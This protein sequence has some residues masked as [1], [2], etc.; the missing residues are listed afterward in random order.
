MNCIIYPRLGKLDALAKQIIELGAGLAP[1]A[2]RNSIGGMRLEC[3]CDEEQAKVIEAMPDAD[4]VGRD[5]RD[6]R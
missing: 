1:R 5:E 4:L 3:V 2:V 6:E